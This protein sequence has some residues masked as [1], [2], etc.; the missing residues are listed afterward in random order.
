MILAAPS[1]VVAAEAS[2]NLTETETLLG[3]LPT[4]EAGPAWDERAGT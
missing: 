3:V 1:S 4:E 2:K